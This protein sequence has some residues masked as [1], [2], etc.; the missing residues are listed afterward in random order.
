[1]NSYGVNDL[2]F[3]DRFAPEWISLWLLSVFVTHWLFASVLVLATLTTADGLKLEK[4]KRNETKDED[5]RG[6]WRMN[7]FIKWRK[8]RSSQLTSTCF[9][10]RTSPLIRANRTQTLT[11]FTGLQSNWFLLG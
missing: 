1:M 5:E 4:I 3:F 11:C 7:S 6:K 8:R 9:T 2:S 10:C